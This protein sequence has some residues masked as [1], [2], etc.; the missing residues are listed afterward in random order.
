[1]AAHGRKM[2]LAAAKAEER[3]IDDIKRLPAAN[4]IKSRKSASLQF[5]STN[6][7]LPAEP[8]C[9]GAWLER[10]GPFVVSGYGRTVP[11]SRGE[12][13]VA[14]DSQR[15]KR[16]LAELADALREAEIEPR[17]F[18]VRLS[19][20]NWMKLEDELCCSGVDFAYDPATGKLSGLTYQGI[21][22]TLQQG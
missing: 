20:D 14:G 19:L 21:R 10:A 11:C 5:D 18:E 13:G 22:F 7:I 9:E 2:S 15:L 17:A 3:L 1:M 16:L 6:C 8:I 12:F 4:V